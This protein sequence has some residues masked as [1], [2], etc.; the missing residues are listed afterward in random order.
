MKILC[1][2]TLQLF[3]S[4]SLSSYADNERAASCVSI[5]QKSALNKWKNRGPD[6]FKYCTDTQSA[7]EGSLFTP[8]DPETAINTATAYYEVTNCLGLKWQNLF[9]KISAESGFLNSV[10]GPKGDRGIGQLTS[11]AIT[12][13]QKNSDWIWNKIRQNSTTTCKILTN[14]INK[15]GKSNFFEFPT[16]LSCAVMSG[17]LGL[18]RNILFSAT[19]NL[20]N[21]RYVEQAYERFNI[22]G[23]FQEAGYESA[24]HDRIKT[25][26]SFIGYNNGGTSAVI[27]LD[28]YLKSRIDFIK[29]KN[30]ELWKIDG[31][32]ID[33][34]KF[35]ALLSADDFDFS[36]GAIR[37]QHLYEKLPHDA[38]FEEKSVLLRNISVSKLGFPEWLRIWQTN[39]GPG[40]MNGIYQVAKTLGNKDSACVNLDLFKLH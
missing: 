2:I 23:K 26:L 6:L 10:V 22:R 8:F 18:Y 27:D 4:L 21:Q 14:K 39:G 33:R 12:D 40:Y 31:T 35:L 9:P 17:E 15:W 29:R 3:L 38:S 5:S 36:M 20:L 32:S 25:M 13:V 34:R 37:Y 7:L 19:L 11:I 1:L 28:N 24:P 30:Q 16:N